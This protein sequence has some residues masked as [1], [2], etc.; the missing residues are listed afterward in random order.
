M[1]SQNDFWMLIDHKIKKTLSLHADT[2]LQTS[3]Q[4]LG[5]RLYYQTIETRVKDMNELLLAQNSTIQNLSIEFIQLNEQ[6]LKLQHDVQL[7][8][9]MSTVCIIGIIA[10][11]CICILSVIANIY[12]CFFKKSQKYRVQKKH[13][14]VVIKQ[15]FEIEEQT[16]GQSNFGNK[17]KR[18]VCDA[19]AMGRFEPERFSDAINNLPVVQDAVVDGLMDEMDTEEGID[20]DS[21][22]IKQ[23]GNVRNDSNDSVLGN[24]VT[25][26]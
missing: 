3:I 19:T 26:C 21:E 7:K 12:Y 25:I 23:E 1:D 24:F 9:S 18:Q 16:K 22:E 4:K 17:I 13:S 14:M 5:E 8:N 10:I 6:N 15:K 11:G 20:K 2:A